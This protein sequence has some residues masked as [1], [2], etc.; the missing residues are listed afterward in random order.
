MKPEDMVQESSSNE[1]IDSVTESIVVQLQQDSKKSTKQASKRQSQ[2]QVAQDSEDEES[3]PP[4][5]EFTAIS[6]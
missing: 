6:P 3:E 5:V 4:I 2:V 1:D